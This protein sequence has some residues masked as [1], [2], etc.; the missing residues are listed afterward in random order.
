M[1]KFISVLLASMA[2]AGAPATAGAAE[3]VVNMIVEPAEPVDPKVRKAVDELLVAMKFRETMDSN[4]QVMLKR[5]PAMMLQNATA[6]I[7]ANTKLSADERKAELAKAAEKIP[8]AIKG[9]ESTFT[10]KTLLDEL[11]AAVVPL[12]ARRFSVA[13]LGELA[14]FYRTQAGQKMLATFPQILAESMQ[15]SQQVMGPRIQKQ[16]DQVVK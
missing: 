3:P 11:Y 13:E 6:G 8:K 2:M 4:F 7:N 12:Y 15:V 9:M 5:M 10:D 14:R 16:I 1:K